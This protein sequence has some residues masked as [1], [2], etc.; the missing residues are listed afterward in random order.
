MGG[1]ISR[2]LHL[3]LFPLV[4]F[5]GKFRKKVMVMGKAIYGNHLCDGSNVEISGMS[6]ALVKWFGSVSFD[7]PMSSDDVVAGSR[8]VRYVG[9]IRCLGGEVRIGTGNVRPTKY[10]TLASGEIEEVVFA[11]DG[12]IDFLE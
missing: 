11:G 4:I 5:V 12:A 2:P 3:K 9:P 1:T 7:P 6:G 10:T 8:V